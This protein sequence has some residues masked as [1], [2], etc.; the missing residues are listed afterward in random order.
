MIINYNKWFYDHHKYLL[1][2]N[3]N[4][5]NDT[6]WVDMNDRYKRLNELKNSYIEGQPFGVIGNEDSFNKLC[7]LLIKSGG[8]SF[9][10]I[11]NG[12]IDTYQMEYKN[13]MS[14]SVV[15]THAVMFS[16][17]STDK[18][19]VSNDKFSNDYIIDVPFYMMHFGERDN[20]I[21]QQLKKMHTTENE[22]YMPI[23][24]FV[25]SGYCNILG[26]TILCCVNGLISN[27]CKIAID[28]KGFKFKIPWNGF[29][30][31]EFI[32][33]KL[34][35]SFIINGEYDAADIINNDDG[36]L[37]LPIDYDNDCVMNCI[38][39]IYDPAFGNNNVNSVVNFGILKKNQ[40]IINN[41]QR[42]T[43]NDLKTF[44]SGTVKIIV[45]AI[46]Y[47]NEVYGLYPGVNY[48]DILDS[49]NV[50]TDNGNVVRV[51]DNGDDNIIRA[52]DA[53]NINEMEI[54]TPP[55]T[56]NRTSK[57]SFTIIQNCFLYCNDLYTL[58]DNIGD[59]VNLIEHIT[60]LSDY[61]II[62]NLLN[63]LKNIQYKL[64]RCYTTY[65]YF[66]QL[67]S[68]IDSLLINRF[69]TV[70]DTINDIVIFVENIWSQSNR[71]DIK[72]YLIDD[73]YSFNSFIDIIIAPL[74]DPAL[75]TIL[76]ISSLDKSFYY[77]EM[78][79]PIT[80][81][82]HP[83]SEQCFIALKYDLL[84]ECWVFTLPNIKHFKGIDNAFYIN[85][86]LNGDEI[87]KFFVL[88]TDTT[89]VSNK[90]I[91]T[92]DVDTV[93]DFDKF[94]DE[95]EK[96]NGYIRYW[97]SE[98]KL[99]KLS[100]LF[101]QKY[102]SDTC[103]HILSKI[104]KN[105]LSIDDLLNEYQSEIH[106]EPSG[107]SSLNYD[108]YTND[109]EMAPFAI[110]YLFYTLNLMYN[111]EDKL[112]SYLF[113]TLTNKNY[114]KRYVDLNMERL[115]DD[116]IKYKVNYSE[117]CI[118]PLNFN[119]IQTTSSNLPND[120]KLL[121]F[122][123]ISMILNGDL[124]KYTLNPYKYSF[125]VYSDTLKHY[126]ITKDDI[127]KS[128]YICYD[129]IQSR[130]Y[131]LY[132][133]HDSIYIA[134]LVSFYI[135]YVYDYINELRTNYNISYNQ[136]HLL[137]SG[138]DTINSVI[139]KINEFVD[140]SPTF[141]HPDTNDVISYI[142]NNNPYV[143][144][145][146]SLIANY[147]YITYTYVYYNGKSMMLN[148]FINSLLMNIRVIYKTTGF[149]N[150]AYP[151]IRKFYNH[152]KR[153]NS[154]M[155]MY[156]F[157]KWL[158]DFDIGLLRILD[159][160]ISNN[161]NYPFDSRTLFTSYANAFTS[162]RTSINV[163]I[164]QTNIIIERLMDNDIYHI[165]DLND[166]LSS[167]IN[168]YIFDLYTL[169]KIEYDS[170]IEYDDEPYMCTIELPIDEHFE[171]PITY[172]ENDDTTVLLFKPVYDII[173]NKYIITSLT[174]VCEYAFFNGDTI[175]N[176]TMNIIDNTGNTIDSLTCDITFKRISSTS[177]NF[178]SFDQIINI[179]NTKMD[180]NNE[181]EKYTINDDNAI[182]NQKRTSMNY[183]LLV[184][185]H[186][187][188]MK[189]DIE[190]VLNPKTYEQHS[191]D[192]LYM[193]NQ[194]INTL[195]NDI[196]GNH[197]SSKVFFKPS[198][199]LHITPD[200][201]GN[202]QSIGKGYFVGQRIYLITEDNYIFPIIITQIDHSIERGFIEAKV[203]NRNCKWFEL[204]DKTKITNYLN[205][206]ITCTI[207]PDNISNWLDEYNNSNY[208]SYNIPNID[209]SMDYSDIDNENMYSLPGDPIFVSNNSNYVY[210]RLNWM[211]NDN[212]DNRFIDDEH[213]K[214][215]FIYIGQS[216]INETVNDEII[217]KMINH[218]MSPL[219]N[220]EL[221]PI[222]RDEPNDHKIWDLERKTFK[223]YI[224]K[225]TAS[226]KTLDYQIDNW[227]KEL[228][229]PYTEYQKDNIRSIID[230]YRLLK[231]K[232]ESQIERVTYYMNNLEPMTTWYNVNAYEDT[233]V[234]ISN[235]RAKTVTP[236][237]VEHI[238]DL[239][240]TD[241]M[242]VYLYDWENKHWIDPSLYTI[243]KN[244][245]NDISI[246]N[247][248]NY[249]TSNILYSITINPSD[250]FVPSSKILI[251]FGYYK[252]N[253]FDSINAV[254]TTC[255][256]RFKPIL[257]L[258]DNI[259]SNPYG[260]LYLR[261]HFDGYERYVFDDYNNP[262]DI[263]F[264]ECFL[265]KRPQTSSKYTQSPCLRYCDLS[266]SNNDN[267]YDYTH[268]DLY[269]KI[270]FND[271]DITQSIQSYSYTNQIIQP[272]DSFTSDTKIKLICIQNNDNNIY[273]GNI[274]T[275]TF[276]AITSFDED[277]NPTLTILSSSYNAPNGNY[278][279]TVLQD[280]EYAMCGGIISVHVSS[281]STVVSDSLNKW[282]KIPQTYSTYRILPNEFVIVPHDDVTINISHKTYVTIENKYDKSFIDTILSNNSNLYNPYEYY[283]DT[284]NEVRYPISNVRSNDNTTRL[285]ID[286]TLNPNVNIV[287]ST[288]IGICRYSLS[289]IPKDGIINVN[290]YIPNPLSRDRYEF[291]LNGKC[292]TNSP[293]LH[294]ISPT[295]IQLCNMTSL[296]NFEIIELVDDVN[297]SIVNKTGTVY[298]GLD[299][300]TFFS[301]YKYALQ[302]NVNIIS[303][304][305]GYLFYNN[306]SESLFNYTSDI[307]TNPN[308]NDIDDDIL[309][310]ITVDDEVV[311]YDQIHNIPTLN[312]KPLRHLTTTSLGIT[313]VELND[314]IKLYDKIWC[315]EAITNPFFPITHRDGI[316]LKNNKYLR[317]HIKS[318]D[319]FDNIPS[320]LNA[321]YVV[322]ASGNVND[323]FTIYISDK[324]NGKID[325]SSHTL[326]IIPFIKT[327]VYVVL[328]D[329]FT[330]K[331]LHTT[332]DDS[333][334]KIK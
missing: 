157:V 208:V 274:S 317:L 74:N 235:G 95:I 40:L 330:N 54:C 334:I 243:T 175:E 47:F 256:V 180:I 149:D 98:N 46:K 116:E 212:I 292:I 104:L 121:S 333:S 246:D 166:Y 209:L 22:Y 88:Y 215:N 29:Y 309:N 299:G 228:D 71:N 133:Y 307:I 172:T 189:H 154:T 190:F 50:Y 301:S 225:L 224:D 112:Q 109:S 5:Y 34:D 66:N 59:I 1:G 250:D 118:A 203:D 183:E 171:P 187:K 153:I 139:N 218:H 214:Y 90:Y 131:V 269:V 60:D 96:Y 310:N 93:F 2:K 207:I 285:T 328:D 115:F 291:W 13:A 199:V 329:S 298:I 27:N 186:F 267:T 125:N 151:R 127:D 7:D 275:L 237:Y 229:K 185:N 231:T 91:E 70:I 77:N 31:A 210:T 100:L 94:C 177:D 331:W 205:N 64:N 110:N 188:P 41:L 44:K 230:N 296:R 249:K 259:P 326:K 302:S 123:G 176:A 124:S 173:N 62:N 164:A 314:I 184:G 167:I 244:I 105:K 128:Y 227:T 150:Y 97:S 111:N 76:K 305:I 290:G 145:F 86:G 85:D 134:K 193:S 191:I 322:Y 221:Y 200:E 234:Y 179:H 92:M 289:R 80:Y 217:I 168:D 159:T 57:T 101:E 147:N 65:I 288:Y 281:S 239:Q 248:D 84:N 138:I 14:G 119:N 108:K 295:S 236:S 48:Y 160:L 241:D 320:T 260:E 303:Q 272:I 196:F 174:K 204:T 258:Y 53:N 20:F 277:D 148:R 32:I 280:Y 18:R 316:E 17:K 156:E 251:Y 213:K 81:Y 245:V 135:T 120:D 319:E 33:Y 117:Y 211:F 312:G 169:H 35:N 142:V 19:Y 318:I 63:P 79:K 297:D 99:M 45:Y 194:R 51:D 283:Y 226:N 158:D 222:L 313:N 89:C 42:K 170:S 308:N 61:E 146:N 132:S 43:I 3:D 126:M 311:S 36:Q 279:C 262:S 219:T 223:S 152:L 162:Y 321:K 21:H 73:L 195:V 68:L 220:Q 273:N 324:Q 23:D 78:D 52:V 24:E 102:D 294:I 39:N 247:K 75:K 4:N 325:E 12:L 58:N 106:Y 293:D 254:E 6:K 242:G 55:I 178:K 130:D 140:T 232:N 113:R 10:D 67:T 270:P 163:F 38:V 87:F 253:I 165:D 25:S 141:I 181:F 197:I 103:V 332:F 265:I 192:R 240:Y 16:C 155:N 278:I 271:I 15:N 286:Q 276:D 238:T 114:S 282:I 268:F 287:K 8:Y 137:Q 257:S 264:E 252:S 37:I 201:N 327:G 122:Y 49:R 304:K 30:D 144:A 9:E 26:F 261:K 82:N 69:K 136:T 300:Q 182:V 72:K 83:V 315:K 107:I 202:I 255:D 266:L 56:L 11:N 161:I 206:P 323:Y 284:T 306:Q 198:N 263:S 216:T 129:N 233:L 28:D 143:Y